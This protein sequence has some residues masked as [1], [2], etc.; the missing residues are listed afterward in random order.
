MSCP[1]GCPN[2]T[3][4]PLYASVVVPA[5]MR[6][7]ETYRKKNPYSLHPVYSLLCLLLVPCHLAAVPMCSPALPA[8]FAATH[9]L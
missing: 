3:T 7:G 5:W 1:S 2:P 6:P 9:A 4:S 8:V